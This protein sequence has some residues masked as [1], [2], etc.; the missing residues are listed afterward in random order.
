MEKGSSIV[1]I[2]EHTINT[3]LLNGGTCIDIGCLG[4]QFSEAMRDYGLDVIAFDIQKFNRIP[5]GVRYINAAVSTET[6][7]YWYT[8]MN[9][10]QATCISDSGIIEV[11]GISLNEVYK[12]N[13]GEID[14]LKCDAEGHE[15]IIFS[16]ENFKPIPKQLSIEFHLHS[17]K[18]LHDRLYQKCMGNILKYYDV[19]QHELTSQHGAGENYW[20]SLFILKQKYY[21]IRH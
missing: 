21:G 17:Q 1:C 18:D 13:D 10:K 5:N 20:D 4:F 9:D 16:D 6:K 11:P 14:V 8:P 7:P 12:K 2:A 15:Y 3:D 19:V